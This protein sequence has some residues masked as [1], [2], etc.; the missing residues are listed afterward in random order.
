MSSPF[1]YWISSFNSVM[2]SSSLC[3][4]R[5]VSWQD[6]LNWLSITVFSSFL[7]SPRTLFLTCF[8]FTFSY[9]LFTYVSESSTA[10]SISISES[11]SISIGL[12]KLSSRRYSILFPQSQTLFTR[13]EFFCSLIVARYF[14]LVACCSL[15]FARCSLLVACYFLLVARCL[16]LFARCSLLFPRCLLFVTFCLLLVTFHSL[17]VTCCS[18]LDKK[19]ERIKLFNLW[20]T[21]KVR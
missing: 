1:K 10:L 9:N 16:L 6:S 2:T 19:F 11:I 8:N 18:L 3:L 12:S 15:L 17:L 21:W 7:K 20:M 5:D 14:L 4:W 13:G